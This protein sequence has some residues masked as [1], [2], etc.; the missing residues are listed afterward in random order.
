MSA[1]SSTPSARSKLRREW[2]IPVGALTLAYLRSVP[3]VRRAELRRIL[4]DYYHVDEVREIMRKNR[5]KVIP[6]EVEVSAEMMENIRAFPGCSSLAFVAH[7]DDCAHFSIYV[8]PFFDDKFV[9]SDLHFDFVSSGP[10]N[11]TELLARA[12]TPRYS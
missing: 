12:P 3:A 7:K 6:V 9:G 10:V 8:R 4:T 11:V 2:Q 1:R 5:A